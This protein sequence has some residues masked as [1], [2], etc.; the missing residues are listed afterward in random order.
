MSVFN[1]DPYMSKYKSYCIPSDFLQHIQ[2]A[3]NILIIVNSSPSTVKTEHWLC[4]FPTRKNIEY[5]DPLGLPYT[6]YTP[7]I[8]NFLEQSGKSIIENWKRV[9]DLSTKSCD[10]HALLYLIFRRRGHTYMKF[11][12]IYCEIPRLNDFLV[13]N[14]ISYIYNINFRTLKVKYPKNVCKSVY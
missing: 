2:H 4:I 10:F 13:K 3:Y 9:Q 5:S 7:H 12:R 8:K 14:T 6:F 11:L 1:M